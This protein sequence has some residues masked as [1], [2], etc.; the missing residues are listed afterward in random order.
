MTRAEQ[1]EIW[2]LK[3]LHPEMRWIPDAV[4]FLVLEKAKHQAMRD[5]LAK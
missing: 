4:L 3:Q 1:R 2:V 5:L